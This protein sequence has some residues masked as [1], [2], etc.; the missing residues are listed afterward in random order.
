M[1]NDNNT[2]DVPASEKEE[3]H[4][5]RMT[6]PPYTLVSENTPFNRVYTGNCFC[7]R[8]QFEIS[9]RK[10]LDSKFCHCCTSTP[11]HVNGHPLVSLAY[12]L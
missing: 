12:P 2:R 4:K 8:V 1:S 10:P 5:N 7:N 11:K 9:R 3:V 6:R